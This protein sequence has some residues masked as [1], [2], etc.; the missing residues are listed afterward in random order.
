MFHLSIH[1]NHKLIMARRRYK[2]LVSVMGAAIVT[3]LVAS[4][5]DPAN[6]EGGSGVSQTTISF[7]L[8][9]STDSRTRS[10]RPSQTPVAPQQCIDITL[11]DA[12]PT[13]ALTETVTSMDDAPV[14][15]DGASATRGIPVFTENFEDVHGKFFAR[16]FSVKNGGAVT[17]TPSDALLGDEPAAFTLSGDG[18]YQ[19]DYGTSYRWPSNH[20]MYFFFN[21]P[22]RNVNLVTGSSA[23]PVSS[24]QYYSD[25]HI[26]F[27]YTSPAQAADQEDILFASRTLKME[28]MNTDNEILFFHPLTGVKFKLGT[29]SDDSHG[30]TINVTSITL[31][32]LLYEGTCTLTTVNKND[33]AANHSDYDSYNRVA[34]QFTTEPSPL[35]HD[36]TLQPEGTVNRQ[37]NTAKASGD[38]DFPSSFYGDENTLGMGNLNSQ[39]YAQTFW[40]I[41]QSVAGKTITITYEVTFADGTVT[42]PTQVEVTLPTGAA[43]KAGELHTYTIGFHQTYTS[44]DN[45]VTGNKLTFAPKNTG[46]TNA[47][48]RVALVANWENDNLVVFGQYD[49]TDKIN[50][51]DWKYNSQDGFYYYCNPV[52][53]GMSAPALL[54][55]FQA[56]TAPIAGT[57]LE[58]STIVQA[59]QTDDAGAL[60]NVT[61]YWGEG[62]STF[63]QANK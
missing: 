15:T 51:T 23:D 61:T 56:D 20:L 3:V 21:S 43:W 60:T 62:A 1:T 6:Q 48:L 4:C 63:I 36:F 40:L 54:T 37:S 59:V 5:D 39:N 30:V 11:G 29:L 28:T 26:T 18:S 19:H 9:G 52:A 10:A 32:D 46:N 33:K 16:T 8:G 38:Y 57:H 27:D 7:Q 47:Y 22:R 24:Q 2:H 58:L 45:E 25:G 31:K 13:L 50:A 34:W 44:I 53:P 55:N 14:L 42:S 12:L 49:M 41:P 17:Y 35:K